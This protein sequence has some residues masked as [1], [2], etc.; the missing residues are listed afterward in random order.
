MKLIRCQAD[1]CQFVKYE[2]EIV[3]LLKNIATV[4]HHSWCR[5]IGK[6]MQQQERYISTFRTSPSQGKS[7]GKRPKLSGTFRRLS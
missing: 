7:I 1:F 6:A 2:F 4:R 3:V 5:F